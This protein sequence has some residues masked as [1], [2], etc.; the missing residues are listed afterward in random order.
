MLA[1]VYGTDT[2]GNEAL[3]EEWNPDTDGAN[4]QITPAGVLTRLRYE[5]LVRTLT[6]GEP[7][8]VDDVALTAAWSANTQSFTF[9]QDSW[10]YGFVVRLTKTVGCDR[11]AKCQVY[12]CDWTTGPGTA[13]IGN[14]TVALAADIADEP[15]YSDHMVLFTVPRM[16]KAGHYCIG[17]HYSGGTTGTISM[18][19][20][21]KVFTNGARWSSG[22]MDLDNDYWLRVLGGG[23]VCQD[24]VPTGSTAIVQL[25]N[26]ELTFDTPLY[27]KFQT[28]ESVY[29]YSGVLE[30]ETT[31]QSVSIYAIG[32]VA[33]AL[34]IDCA[35]REVYG[36][37][38]G[39]PIPYCAEWSDEWAG[40]YLNP[41]ANSM[42]WTE[43]GIG[44]LTFVTTWRGRWS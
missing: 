16:F 42:S 43:T 44:T 21:Y 6:A 39:L 24:E 14:T 25:D 41:G 3:L 11:D 9:D 18:A 33:E 28:A 15:D 1:R 5:G 20:G 10:L 32:K 38:L 35:K 8:T 36:G 34:T 30:N 23:S 12:E 2:D 40:I 27:V 19:Y 29:A 22:T 4:E 26:I 13:L 17:V 37:E 31:G 7:A